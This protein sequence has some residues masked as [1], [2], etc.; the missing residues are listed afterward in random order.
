MPCVERKWAALPYR[1]AELT[2]LYFLGLG[3]SSRLWSQVTPLCTPDSDHCLLWDLLALFLGNA[4]E[5]KEAGLYLEELDPNAGEHELQK[6]G[7][8]YDVPNGPDGHKHTLN[9]VL[10]W[11]E[12]T[13]RGKVSA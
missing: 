10:Q 7:D 12:G 2:S 1:E 6:S 13:G 3:S 4:G 8:N 11:E 5:G 9:H